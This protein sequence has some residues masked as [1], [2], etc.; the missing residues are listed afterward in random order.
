MSS[1]LGAGFLGGGCGI[2]DDGKSFCGIAGALPL[3]IGIELG[4]GVGGGGIGLAERMQKLRLVEEGKENVCFLSRS[5]RLWMASGIAR[6]IDS[7][8][9]RKTKGQEASN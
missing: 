6:A 8:D 9:D 7:N 4:C 5:Y 1:I 2:F 3:E